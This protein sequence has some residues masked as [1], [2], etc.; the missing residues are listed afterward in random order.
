MLI[1]AAREED[2]TAIEEIQ[3]ASPEASQWTPRD[4]LAYEC[5][6]AEEA[7]AVVG[8]SVTRQVAAEEWEILNLAVAPSAR[9]N[10]LGSRLLE[11]ILSRC[12]GDVFLEVRASN[13]AARKLYE[14]TGFR[15]ITER[16]QYYYNPIETG[17]VMKLH[18]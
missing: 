1:R 8:F 12:R 16:L 18:S 10:G 17:I 4:Y 9:R 15:T 11:E 2:L 7:G 14:N 13:G 5:R 6:I 3:S